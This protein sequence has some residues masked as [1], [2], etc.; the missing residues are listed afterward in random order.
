MK[1]INQIIV[2]LLLMLTTSFLPSNWL[3]AQPA[4][5]SGFETSIVTDFCDSFT[6]AAPR[7]NKDNMTVEMGMMI[8]PLLSKYSAEIKKEWGLEISN[9]EDLRKMGEKIGQFAA[10]KCPSFLEFIK[11]NLT[12][13]AQHDENNSKTYAGKLLKIE[14]APFAYLLVQDRKGKTDKLYWLEFFEGADKLTSQGSIYLNKPV[15][16]T[17]KEVEVYQAVA[18]E[19]KTIKVVTKIG[20]Q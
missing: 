20:F 16:L 3:N 14:G 6:K 12:E 7:I 17:Y 19:Y 8:V 4:F 15:T 10:V 5:G 1:K 2:P 11:D 13:I 18:K 9:K